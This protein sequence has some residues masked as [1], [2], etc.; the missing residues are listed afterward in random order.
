L[1]RCQNWG[2]RHN[3]VFKD[4]KEI[5]RKRASELEAKG[6]RQCDI[7]EALGVSKGAV[8][9]WLNSHASDAEAWRS[10]PQGHRPAK[11]TE[12]QRRLI[13]D[14]LSHGAE[15]Y[16]FRGELWTCARIAEVIREEFGVAY[17]KAHVSRLLRAWQW[18]PQLPLER[19]LQRDE[20]A[21]ERWRMEAWPALKKRLGKKAP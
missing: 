19:A 14:L 17:H 7:A 1:C 6:W 12:E 3:S 11:L 13:P 8:S 2:M 5:R 16:G 10:K 4:W 20:A 18:T 9:Q 21:I 15:A